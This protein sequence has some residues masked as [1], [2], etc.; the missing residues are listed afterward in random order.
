VADPT[1]VAVVDDHRLF[2]EG[3][4]A[5]FDTVADLEL[6]ADG[7]NGHDA[8]RIAREL[9]PAVML[10][11]LRMPE[12]NGI[13]ALRRI[14]RE[15]PDVTV[16][17]LTM[18]DDS[19]PVAQAL[20]EGAAGYVLKGADPVDLLR[21]VRSAG[22]GE[23]LLTG[24][25][26]EQAQGMLSGTPTRYRPPLPQLSERERAVLDLLAAG[27]DTARIAAALHLS[28]KTVRNYLTV[29]PR[30]LGVADRQTAIAVARQA[31]LGRG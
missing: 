22:R 26:A 8:I 9:R 29:I 6:V 3:L 1:R 31:G 11:D 27:N 14:R 2:R 30:R 17:M 25:A 13:E 18:V 23:L 16:V 15:T 21:V 4:R 7:E 5:L 28:Q 24:V 20:R 19:E 12:L 10:L